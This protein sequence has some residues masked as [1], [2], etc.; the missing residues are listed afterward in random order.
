[1]L[2]VC[3]L[4]YR[5]NPRL[6]VGVPMLTGAGYDVGNTVIP[7]VSVFYP[8]AGFSYL[9]SFNIT[10]TIMVQ[11]VNFAIVRALSGK[12]EDG[13]TGR[14]VK[15]IFSS[16]PLDAYLV[17]LFLAVTGIRLPET[18]VTVFSTI[19]SANSFLVMLMIG[20]KLELSLSGNGL[21][22]TIGMVV[23]RLCSALVFSAA[24]ILFLPLPELAKRVLIMAYLGSPSAVSTIYVRKLGYKGSFSADVSM[25]SVLLAVLLIP[26]VQLFLKGG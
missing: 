18:A 7:F 8:G 25:L 17:V 24:T 2:L 6:P 1:M 22:D 20:L 3:R 11:G 19:A 10:N 21:T 4:L 16:V 14:F 23:L 26:T 9:I 12:K 13:T 15:D 5:H